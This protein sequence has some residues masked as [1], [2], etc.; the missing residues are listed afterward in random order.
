[1]SV[2]LPF[3]PGLTSTGSKADATEPGSLVEKKKK[4]NSELWLP[5]SLLYPS[6]KNPAPGVVGV[7]LSGRAKT[8]W[9]KPPDRRE[10]VQKP[11]CLALVGQALL[12]GRLEP[13]LKQPFVQLVSRS[14]DMSQWFPPYV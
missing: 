14:N 5:W 6:N 1:M 7:V 12:G 8:L 10:E 3:Q 4:V 2:T 13:G 11:T 9:A